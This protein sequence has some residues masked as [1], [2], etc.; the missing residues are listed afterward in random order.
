MKRSR[1]GEEQVSA[2]L[3]EQERRVLT[4]DICR[5]HWVGSATF[6]TWKS[7][8][9]G[10]EVLENETARLKRLMTGAMLGN[11]V[12]NDDAAKRF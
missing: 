5:R 8:F 1:F 7:R 4:E 11:A 2:I 12:L 6:C 10:L 3:K 9:G